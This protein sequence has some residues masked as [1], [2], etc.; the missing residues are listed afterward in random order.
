MSGFELAFLYGSLLMYSLGTLAAGS[1]ARGGDRRRLNQAR[2]TGALGAA[3]QIGVLVS[4]GARLGHFPID[5]AFEAF[6]FLAA[7]LTTLALA[8][9][10]L[11][12]LSILVIGTLPLALVTTLLALALRLAPAPEGPPL[13]G[14]SSPWTALHIFV[15][16]GAYGAFAFAFVTGILYL[17]AQRRLKD[18]AVSS[19]LGFMPSLET[20]ARLNVRSIAI[21]AALLAGGI[22]VGYF[23][24]RQFYAR[25]F[26]RLDPKIILSCAT[27]AAYL[28]VLALSRR[29][30]FR[31]RR[32]ALAS[33][34]AFFLVL[35]NFWASVFW[36]DLHRYR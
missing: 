20:V 32:T 18:H 25:N 5:G 29:P 27:L 34:L 12:R 13:A 11:R 15:A 9:D 28:A 10:G 19:M 24:A 14:V 6:V 2:L 33:V 22:V 23:Y 1:A 4:M 36:S 31:G 7:A 30:A 3:Y 35:T 8:L 16:L 17:V 26:D 21:G